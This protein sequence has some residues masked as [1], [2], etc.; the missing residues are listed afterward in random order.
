[1]ID[2]SDLQ[3]DLFSRLYIESNSFIIILI[4]Q[5]PLVILTD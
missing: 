5:I 1:L 4:R 3:L 2:L